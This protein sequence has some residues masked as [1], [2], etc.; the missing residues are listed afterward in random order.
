MN[1]SSF[2]K[3]ITVIFLVSTYTFSAPITLTN[4][5]VTDKQTSV[6]YSKV[7]FNPYGLCINAALSLAV[8]AL[9]I[10]SM[11]LLTRKFKT[12]LVD[13]GVID[14]AADKPMHILGMATLTATTI[15]FTNQAIQN[16]IFA[17][18]QWYI[19]PANIK[20]VDLPNDL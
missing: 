2:F 13:K 16:F 19:T 8:S 20:A 18:Q 3:K 7:I 10:G 9:S 11:A 17:I 12:G 6:F 1:A 4:T 15:F 14:H 5:T